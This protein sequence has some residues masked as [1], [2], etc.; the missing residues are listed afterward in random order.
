MVFNRLFS[1]F[2]KVPATTRAQATSATQMQDAIVR[3]IVDDH[4]NLHDFE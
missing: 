1:G 4:I 3:S 2:R